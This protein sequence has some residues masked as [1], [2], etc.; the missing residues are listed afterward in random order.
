[1]PRAGQITLFIGQC[2]VEPD[3]VG[4]AH[5]E[6][7]HRIGDILKVAVGYSEGLYTLGLAVVRRISSEAIIE[8]G[9]DSLESWVR[10]TV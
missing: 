5:G 8:Q 7:R 3:I 1:M 2:W 9:R 4:H 6:I 10:N